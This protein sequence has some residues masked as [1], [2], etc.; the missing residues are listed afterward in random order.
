MRGKL[1]ITG[2][3]GLLLL[4]GACGRAKEAIDIDEAKAW[5]TLEL[6]M[7]PE[8][9]DASLADLED[10]PI[11]PPP[12]VGTNY[13]PTFPDPVPFDPSEWETNTPPPSVAVPTAKKGGTLRLD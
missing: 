11:D 6:G 7:T 8:E 13:D 5:E 1:T 3:L 12:E 2:L 10:V 9:F 4:A